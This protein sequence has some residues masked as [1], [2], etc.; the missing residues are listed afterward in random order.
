MPKFTPTFSL[1][2]IIGLFMLWLTFSLLKTPLD[3]YR[4]GITTQGKV[5]KINS[6]YSSGRNGGYRYSP[7]V[8]F[9]TKDQQDLQF[10]SS[11]GSSYPSYRVGQNVTVI[12]NPS[13][14]NEVS[15]ND[16]MDM[17]LGAFI[18][19]ILA[20]AFTGVGFGSIIAALVRNKT[21]ARLKTSGQKFQADFQQITKANFR[22]N[23]RSPFL[24]LCELND[25]SGVRTLKSDNIWYDPCP[26]LKQG[27]KFDVFIDPNNPKKYYIDLSFLPPAV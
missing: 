26:Y 23:G 4:N 10:Q 27:Q 1:F 19:G 7:V 25:G 12:Y 15:L 16:F 6:Y 17:W 21:I 18:S 8:E 20:L 5:T 3:L 2:G 13:N 9:K 24:I 22:I 11:V 14:L